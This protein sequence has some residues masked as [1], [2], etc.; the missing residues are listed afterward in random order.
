MILGVMLCFPALGE[1]GFLLDQQMEIE[2]AF[3]FCVTGPLR[4]R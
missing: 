4:T 3:V 1:E 2:I